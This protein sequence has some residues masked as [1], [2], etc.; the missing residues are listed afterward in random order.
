MTNTGF[1]PHPETGF[2]RSQD[3]VLA[4]SQY[5]KTVATP[6]EST[7]ENLFATRFCIFIGLSGNDERLVSLLSKVNNRNEHAK[8]EK[9]WGYRLCRKPDHNTEL[10]DDNGVYS[11]EY[12]DLAAGINETLL[13]ICRLAAGK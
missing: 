10:W 3:I 2:S 11:V 7:L 9:Y 12:D 4:Q 8:V 1:L 5:D 6:W 13:N